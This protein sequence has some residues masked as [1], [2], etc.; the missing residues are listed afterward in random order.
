MVYGFLIRFLLEVYVEILTS[1]V[2]NMTELYWNTP[3]DWFLSLYSIFMTT[4]LIALP[5]WM[6]WFLHKNQSQLDEDEF[7]AKYGSLYSS[8]RLKNSGAMYYNFLFLLRRIVFALASV[9]LVEYPVFQI[10]ILFAQSLV[11]IAFL[12]N[13]MPFDTPTLNRL[14][15][16]NEGCIYIVSCLSLSFT[17]IAGSTQTT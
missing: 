14:E 2:L 17:D 1:T 3:G 6:V 5:F 16:F 4:L 15:L 8:L 7:R 13:Y 10:Y 9:F 11:V 12:I